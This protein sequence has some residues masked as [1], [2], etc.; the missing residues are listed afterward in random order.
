MKNR[1]GDLLENTFFKFLDMASR[2]HSH[3]RYIAVNIEV[4][5]G[6]PFRQPSITACT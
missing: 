2:I 1:Y 6:Q 4:D 5:S 3:S